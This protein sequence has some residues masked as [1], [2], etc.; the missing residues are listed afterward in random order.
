MT[1]VY[2]ALY[3]AALTGITWISSRRETAGEYLNSGKNLSAGESAWTTFASLLT[4]YNF[5]LGVTFAYLYGFWYLM[6]FVGAAAAFVVLYF[7]YKKRLLPLQ[8]EH[9][10]FSIGDYFGIRYGA[11]SRIFVNLILCAG[12]FLFLILQIFVNTGLFSALLHIGAIPALLLTT[13]VVCAY[14]WFGGFRVSVKTDIFQG[15]LMLP[16]ILTVFVVPFSFSAEKISSALDPSQFW[17]AVGLMLLQ[18][19]SLLGQAES[20][21][22]IFASRDSASLKKGLIVAFA[23]LALVAG[24][25][26]YLGINFR[27]AGITVD[28]SNLFT[29][30]VLNVLPPW[31]GSLLIVSL[32][33]AF[34]GTIDSSAF[35]LGVLV[36][37]MRNAARLSLVRDTRIFTLLGIAL[38]AVASLYLFSFLSSVFA[39]IS[40]ISVMGAALLLSFLWKITA[41]EMNTFLVVGTA[42]FILGL[43]FGFVTS[44][45]LTSLIPS[46]AGF[47]AFVAAIVYRKYTVLFFPD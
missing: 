26:A 30:G 33:A 1:I 7:F 40:L 47:C 12:L 13:G 45:P 28:P 11:P 36:A 20:F 41:F 46:A 27:F 10:L 35:A 44:D 4:G 21:Q 37:R 19:F 18:F 25:I 42:A 9:D 17:F 22:R 38:S 43:M 31:L 8:K 14:L 29:E 16:I 5:V 15:V 23:L 3:L 39:L 2:L 34:M 32:I 24:S 6:A